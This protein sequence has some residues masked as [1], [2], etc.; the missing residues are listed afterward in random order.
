MKVVPLK[1]YCQVSG[2]TLAAVR[3][4]IERGI[5]LEG[6]HY[7]KLAHVK[8]RWIDIEAVEQWARNGGGYHKGRI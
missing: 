8:E 4:R 6:I 1:K 5:W 2:E 7:Y 3:Q